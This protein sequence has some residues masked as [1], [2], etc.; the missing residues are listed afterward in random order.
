M[1][2]VYLLP[3][4]AEAKIEKF[5]VSPN[6]DDLKSKSFESNA[7]ADSAHI[8]PIVTDKKYQII[9]LVDEYNL[10]FP[11]NFPPERTYRSTVL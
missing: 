6:F 10:I 3:T 11:I 4:E 5:I 1:G 9:L 8:L 2:T 7:S